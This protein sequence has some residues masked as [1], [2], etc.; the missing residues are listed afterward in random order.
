MYAAAARGPHALGKRA[1][2]AQEQCM[3]EKRD[4]WLRRA[5]RGAT[6]GANLRDLPPAIGGRGNHSA[7]AFGSDA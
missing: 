3:R 4:L 5:R 6:D 7:G 2:Q 1:S